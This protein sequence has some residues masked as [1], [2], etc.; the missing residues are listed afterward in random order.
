M[1]KTLVKWDRAGHYGVRMVLTYFIRHTEALDVDHQTKQ[2]LWDERR[3]AIHYPECLGRNGEKDL[4]DHDNQSL[5]PDDYPRNAASML[6]ILRELAQQGGYVCA[7]YA[8]HHDVVLGYIEPG[9]NVE[10]LRGSW[11]ERNGLQGR[12]AILKTIRLSRVRQLAPMQSASIMAARPR[13]GTICRWHKVG[14]AVQRLVEGETYELDL[15]DLLPEHQEV[16]ASEYLRRSDLPL[17][18]P[19]LDKLL[20]PIGKTL[21]DLDILAAA[22][23]GRRICAQVTY[24]Q[25]GGIGEKL[26]RLRAYASDDTVLVLFCL[27]QRPGWDGDVAVIPLQD[28]FDWLLA[29][30]TGQ[31]WVALN[32]P[33]QQTEKR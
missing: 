24:A 13:Q 28:A 31:Q 18:L 32:F 30:P 15:P 2:Q 8:G 21:R 9:S 5:T 33:A 16:I 1:C 25:L 17:G 7:E 26:E 23:D 14:G 11:G 29:S 19:M 20:L 22:K 6:R 4:R 10:L 3:I 12:P 27:A